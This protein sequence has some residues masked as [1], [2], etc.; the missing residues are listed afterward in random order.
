MSAVEDRPIVLSLPDGVGPLEAYHQPL[1]A[2]I[3]R[4]HDIAMQGLVLDPVSIELVRL[5]C[6]RVHDCRFCQHVRIAAARDGGADE[7]FLSEIDFY[8]T[9]TVLS[10]RQKVMLRV[11]DAHIYGSVPPTLPGQVGEHLTP[12]EAV[13]IVTLVAKFSFQKSLVPLGLEAPPPF[14]YID[15]DND[16]GEMIVRD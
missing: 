15:F 3:L 12:E 7:E 5:R 2:A 16:T 8:E 11:V 13:E 14:V 10:E 4:Y 9:S 1:T 6:A